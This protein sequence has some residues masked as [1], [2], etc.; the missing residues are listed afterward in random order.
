M[1]HFTFGVFPWFMVNPDQ[2][3]FP[4]S[5][6]LVYKSVKVPIKHCSSKCSQQIIS[7]DFNQS[8]RK[9]IIETKT[10]LYMICLIGSKWD[11]TNCSNKLSTEPYGML[12]LV[13]IQ[14]L[15]WN[16][17]IIFTNLIRYQNCYSLFYCLLCNLAQI[18]LNKF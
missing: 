8:V 11:T 12:I 5:L 14:S 16:Y 18:G 2:S 4:P 17:T 9:I 10:M 7:G 13:V 1:K 15:N 3:F 6:C